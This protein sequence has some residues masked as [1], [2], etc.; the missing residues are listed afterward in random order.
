MSSGEP[1]VPPR[2][3]RGEAV[4]ARRKLRVAVMVH[5]DLVPPDP[6]TLSGEELE[7]APWKTEYDVLRTLGELG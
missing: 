4:K 7:K 5:P 6:V 2:R 1:A 3:Q